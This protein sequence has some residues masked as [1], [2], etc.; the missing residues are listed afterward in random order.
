M[1]HT[2]R[3]D[4]FHLCPWLGPYVPTCRRLG[5]WG[6]VSSVWTQCGVWS[7]CANT[8]QQITKQQRKRELSTLKS[9]TVHVHV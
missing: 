4:T 2:P 3:V 9:S 5:L 7:V 6:W 1:R 8:K